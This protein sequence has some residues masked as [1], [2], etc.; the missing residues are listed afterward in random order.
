MASRLLDPSRA[1][2][3][4]DGPPV[5]RRGQIHAST[6]IAKFLTQRHVGRTPTGRCRSSVIGRIHDQGKVPHTS[7]K[8]LLLTELQATQDMWYDD[9]HAF[10]DFRAKYRAANKK[11]PYITPPTRAA[12]DFGKTVSKSDRDDTAHKVQV[13]RLWFCERFF[14]EGGRPLIIMPVENTA[15]RYRDDPP[16]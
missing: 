5:R 10:D 7:R 3:T 1:S 12:W 9:Y 2:T 15:P 11:A 13:F 4:C 6:F 8:R 14:E 16:E